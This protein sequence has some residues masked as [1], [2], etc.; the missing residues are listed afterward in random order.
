MFQHR[1]AIIRGPLSTNNVDTTHQSSHYVAFTG[2]IK[3]LKIKILKY[4]KLITTS[5]QCC[6]IDSIKKYSK[7]AVPGA[8]AICNCMDLYRFM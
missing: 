4:T 1:G 5:W 3:I 7:Q 2:V 6:S 8:A